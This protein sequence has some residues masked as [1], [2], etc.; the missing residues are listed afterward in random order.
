[1][2]PVDSV[3][4]CDVLSRPTSCSS[5]RPSAASTYVP[6]AELDKRPRVQTWVASQ[7]ADVDT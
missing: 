4:S 5:Q 6:G 3:Q 1:M 2:F 7:D